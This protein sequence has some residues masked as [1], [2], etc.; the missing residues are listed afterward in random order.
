MPLRALRNA[1]DSGSRSAGFILG[2]LME[3][4][5]YL[6]IYVSYEKGDYYDN[7]GRVLGKDSMCGSI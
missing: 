6:I 3:R 7:K 5:F 2:F 1:L 4:I